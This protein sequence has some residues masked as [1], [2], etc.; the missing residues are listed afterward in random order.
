VKKAE[1]E[2]VL[3][4]DKKI[5]KGG[6]PGCSAPEWLCKVSRLNQASK[7]IENSIGCG[8]MR[9]GLISCPRL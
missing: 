3:Q 7:Y 4:S 2:L 9:T 5:E 6:A 8:R 1:L